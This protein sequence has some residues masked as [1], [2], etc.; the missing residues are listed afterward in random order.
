MRRQH[1]F[2]PSSDPDRPCERNDS[3]RSVLPWKIA[4]ALH[5]RRRLARC[6]P[7]GEAGWRDENARIRDFWRR[8]EANLEPGFV[9]RPARGRE[10]P[11]SG[12]P[13]PTL[14]LVDTSGSSAAGRRLDG[15]FEPAIEPR[16]SWRQRVGSQGWA[17]APRRQ[18]RGAV[19]AGGLQQVRGRYHPGSRHGL[20]PSAPAEE[21]R[22]L[23]RGEGKAT[24]EGREGGHGRQPRLRPGS[25]STAARSRASENG[26]SD[27]AGTSRGVGDR[28]ERA[29][30]RS[31]YGSFRRGSEGRQSPFRGDSAGA[32]VSL[33]D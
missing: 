9:E 22:G 15:E 20:V 26:R 13:P 19:P 25:G 30:A 1:S 23:R 4:A 5:R 8:S 32:S 24:P 12:R 29:R 6:R 11:R 17:A 31:P 3:V 33:A 27:P 7:K 28:A 18:G 2:G 16:G 21:R 14:G 10:A